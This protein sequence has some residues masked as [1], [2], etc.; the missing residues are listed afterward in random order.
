MNSSLAPPTLHI[1]VAGIVLNVLSRLAETPGGGS[2]VNTRPA[3]S[4]LVGSLGLISMV[5]KSRKAG[6]GVRLC[7]F[8]SSCTSHCGARCTFFSITQRP[9]LLDELIA[10]SACVK[11]S[12]DPV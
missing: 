10:L 9:D 5:R 11:P 8:F 7:S 6:W 2:N 1:L 3:R 12:A 4:R